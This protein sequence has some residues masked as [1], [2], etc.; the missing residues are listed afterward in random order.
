M[1]FSFL[2]NN[3]GISNI[4]SFSLCLESLRPLR[5]RHGAICYK[6][7]SRQKFYKLPG[8]EVRLACEITILL[9]PWNTGTLFF[10]ALF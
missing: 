10:V 8:P 4:F 1:I 7:D 5:R 2:S 3:Y 9:G 6:K